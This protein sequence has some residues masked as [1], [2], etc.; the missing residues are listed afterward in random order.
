MQTLFTS[1][2]SPAVVPVFHHRLNR[3]HSTVGHLL[4][5]LGQAFLAGLLFIV[6]ARFVDFLI[7]EFDATYLTQ[8]QAT[9]GDMAVFNHVLLA[10]QVVLAPT[11]AAIAAVMSALQFRVV[12]V[13][14]G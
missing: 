7:G 12:V 13:I 10:G 2:A 9:V 5:L 11:S 4:F 3:F 1:K 8:I 6:V 14:V